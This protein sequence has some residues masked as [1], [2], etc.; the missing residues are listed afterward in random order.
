MITQGL[1]TVSTLVV[2]APSQ[3]QSP[4]TSAGAEGVRP[5]GGPV[6]PELPSLWLSVD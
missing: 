4:S 1:K 5:L 3:T 6:Q 2:T